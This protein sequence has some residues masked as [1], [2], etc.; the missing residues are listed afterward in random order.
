MTVEHPWFAPYGVLVVAP[1]LALLGLGWAWLVR[2]ANG[3]L[4]DAVAGY[5][6]DDKR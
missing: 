6:A 3:V 1:V 2:R 4:R 5:L